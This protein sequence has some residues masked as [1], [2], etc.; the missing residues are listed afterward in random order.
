M[1]SALDV[2]PNKLIQ[3]VAERL[4]AM[5]IEKPAFVGFVKSGCHAERPPEQPDFWYLRCASIL[6]HAYGHDKIGT[7]ALRRH[8]GGRKNI[9][10]KPSHH[11]PAGGSIIRKALQTLEKHGLLIKVKGG[12][13]LAPKGRALLDSAAKKVSE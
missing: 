7:N 2:N 12:R 4:K 8:Y 3:E 6:R 9:G 10:V 5:K 11:R 13:K 1:I